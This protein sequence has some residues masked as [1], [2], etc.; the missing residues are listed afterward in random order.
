MRD[1]NSPIRISWFVTRGIREAINFI[2][3]RAVTIKIVRFS[4]AISVQ[5]INNSIAISI[6]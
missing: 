3:N 6:K 5:S 1:T 4:V 2:V